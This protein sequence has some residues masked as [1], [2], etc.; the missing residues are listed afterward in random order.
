MRP[1]E[2]LR[3]ASLSRLVLCLGVFASACGGGG[4]GSPK[5]AGDGGGS[6]G[7]LGGSGG[8]G[9]GGGGGTAG[10][11]G[12]SDVAD[13]RPDAVPDATDGGGQTSD[14][15]VPT[16][17]TATV[18]NR[19]QTSIQLSWP[20]PSNNGQA[21]AGYQVRYAKV[22]ITTAN[23]DDTATTTAVAY[24]GT[25]AAPGALD[26][27]LVSNLF[28]E[29][30]YYF[31][32]TGTD[33]SSAHVGTFMMTGTATT[34]RFNVSI[35]PSPSGTNQ[36][37]G[38]ILDGTADVN[39]DGISDLL[40]ATSNDGHAYLF[41]GAANF[42]ATVPAVTFSGANLSFGGDVRAIGD[43]DHDGLQD[44]AISDATGVR[45]LIYK[46]RTTWPMTLA[47]TQADYVISTDASWA[48][49]AFGFSMA[50]LGDFNADG[51]DDFVIGAP[52][53]STRTGRIVVIYGRD[54]FTSLALPNTARSL[55]IGGD[56]TL[57][58]TLFGYSV[59]GLGHFY[60]VTT[61][62]TLVATAPGFGDATNASSNE[63]RVYAFHGGGPGAAISVAG[64]DNVRVGPG[65][66]A[67]I[68]QVTANL[69]PAVNTL[70]ALGVGNSGD[71]LS[72]AGSNG[73]AFVLS[74]TAAAGPLANQLILY[75][76]GGSLV[77]QVIF[78]GGFSGRDGMVSLIGDAKPDVALTSQTAST[79]DIVDGAKIPG[80]TSPVNSQTLGDVHVPMPAGWTGTAAGAGG[81]LIRDINGDGVADFAL[82]DLFGVVPG[83]VAVFW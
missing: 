20:A 73:T 32:V 61:G 30:G 78:G 39:G 11:D 63:G 22:P 12:G 13:V 31:A 49:S 10:K 77:G 71:A 34:A 7:A 70:A 28:I 14:A 74:G 81:N 55:E 52:T 3:L 19:R 21:V 16:M 83:R 72:V 29:T 42:A 33:A 43:I 59:V 5:D 65:K 69:G 66:G 15:A 44:V 24:T 68:G 79:I 58:Q 47:D 82:G 45:V 60:S 35:I 2:R 38:A 56:T 27:L 41:F 40:V 48:N 26:G 37:F 75:Q 18:V 46:G 76:P 23:F 25:P 80:L 64:A 1:F 51:I 9:G 57:T 6:D 67:R 8:G 50:A 54:A 17:L 53:F 36:V 4:S 62:T